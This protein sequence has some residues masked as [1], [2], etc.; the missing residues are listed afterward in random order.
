LILEATGNYAEAIAEYEAAINI[1]PNIPVLYIG[2]GLNYR[3]LQVYA[4]AVAAFTRAN[5]LN[6]ADPLPDLYISRTYA[7]IGEYA[8][9]LQ[10]ARRLWRQLLAPSARKFGVLCNFL[11]R[12]HSAVGYTILEED[13]R[14]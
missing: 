13:R 9:S 10:Y 2:L 8:K 6:P 5:A 1:N 4:E 11:L 12:S 14:R 7:T 3:I